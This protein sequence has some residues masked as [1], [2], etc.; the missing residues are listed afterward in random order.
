MPV[1]SLSVLSACGSIH[2][3]PPCATPLEEEEK[4]CLSL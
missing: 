2:K 1:S 4:S 3:Y